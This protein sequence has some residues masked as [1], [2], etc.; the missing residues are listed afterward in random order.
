MIYVN[1][2]PTEAGDAPTIR[3]V[4]LAADIDPDRAGH[5]RRRRRRGRAPRRVADAH[6]ARRRAR[7]DRHGDAGRMTAPLVIAGRELRSRLL[8]GTGGFTRLQTLGDAIDACES[9]LVTV[10]M[11]RID[12]AAQGSLLDV[13]A[14]AAS[15]CCRTPPAASPPATRS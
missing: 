14:G 15:T 12:A 13:I 10:A 9:E 1:G 2:K 5:R 6:R 8:L 11:R 3:D 4:L 7:R